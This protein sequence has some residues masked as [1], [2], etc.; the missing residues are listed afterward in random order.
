MACH[1]DPAFTPA[2]EDRV[3][4]IFAEMYSVV[5]C[6][7]CGTV[8]GSPL[9]RVCSRTDCALTDRSHTLGDNR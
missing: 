8:A 6:G 5:C 3:R 7:E 4:E 9:A 1:A 2:Q